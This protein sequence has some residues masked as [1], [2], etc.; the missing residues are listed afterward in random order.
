MRN[1]RYAH[2]A[3]PQSP[4][5][6]ITAVWMQMHSPNENK[7]FNMLIKL[8]RNVGRF[9]NKLTANFLAVLFLQWS[10]AALAQ[11]QDEDYINPDRP[12]IADGSK[13]LGAGHFQIETGM[14]KEF[15]RNGPVSDQRLFFPTLLRLG[16]NKDME[17]RVESNTYSRQSISDPENGGDRSEG[18]APISI[19]AKYQMLGVDDPTQP[20]LGVIVRVFPASGSGNFRT[21]HTTG[22]VRLAADWDFASG[23]S[24]NPN[25]GIAVYEDDQNRVFTA[26]LLAMTL[27]YN[28]S[29][30]LNFF[31]DTGMQ[32]PESKNGKSS[33]IFDA[34]M[35][36]LVSRDIQL[37]FSVG[38]GT[39]GLTPPRSFVSLG[40]SKRF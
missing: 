6:T 38:T 13:V 34:G 15:R 11:E 39:A 21:R 32:S 35:A 16:L 37:D 31:V 25:V 14:Q 33:V 17:V 28:P 40:I 4:L 1:F 29:K 20:S 19:G 3:L 26:G 18:S 2:V 27:S 9:S 36:Y 7:V 12:G 5:V 24:L 22:D 8:A 30:T 10:S 23:W